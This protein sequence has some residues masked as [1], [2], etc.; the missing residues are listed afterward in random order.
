M[1]KAMLLITL[2]AALLALASMPAWA[3]GVYAIVK[4]KV[5]GD[6]GPM[7][8]V[9]LDYKN[10]DTGS[11]YSMSTDKNGE[12]FS[13]GILPGPYTVTLTKDGQVIWTQEN[14]RVT[15][16]VPDQTNIANFDLPELRAAAMSKPGQPVMTPE[17]LKKIEEA[18]KETATVKNLNDLMASA[19]T[20]EDGKMWDQAIAIMNQATVAGA[21]RHEVWGK[22]CEIELGAGKNQDAE[23]HC[24]KAITLAEAG[25]N[26]DKSRLAGYHN[27]LG[28]AYA[29]GGKTQEAMA[30]YS[31][32]AQA[33]PANA[34]RYYF[35]LGA[36]LTN[37]FKTDEAIQAFDKVIAADPTYADA[38]YWKAT[39]LINKATTGKD[40]KTGK[41][42]M[43]APP[44]TAEAYQ[45]YLELAPDGRFS[46][47]AKDVLAM[48]GA[49]VQT[50]YGKQRTKK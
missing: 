12:F 6:N 41:D 9:K 25:P 39:N 45:K 50:T 23:E 37:T 17:Q 15:L 18:Q 21:N 32:A 3:Q 7:P 35:N 30:Q 11:K 19:Q 22:L 44:G 46:Q 33:D 16:N 14:V 5:T 20:A 48:I 13:L 34:A 42:R 10:T 28:Q 38:Y 27:N 36:V 40:P 26:T 43:I 2:A 1:K 31:S 24:K 47:A 29:K 49:E 4:G 8:G